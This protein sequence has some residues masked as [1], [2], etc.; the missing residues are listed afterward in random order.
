M[1][2][3][4]FSSLSS[5]LDPQNLLNILVVATGLGMVIFFHEL[6]HFLVAKWCGVYV[7][8][9]SIGF[10]PVILAKQWGETEYALS[11]LPFG[12][13][14]KML[15]QDDMDPGQMT[16]EQVAENPRSY[17]AKNVPQRM[18]I[19]SAGVIMNILTAVIFFMIAFKSGIKSLDPS[20]G[21]IQVGMPAWQH[22]MRAGDTITSINGRDVKEFNDVSRRTAL[23]RGS[24]NVKGIHDDGN[25]FDISIQPEK[26][27]ILRKIGVGP[28]NS[29]SV[30][31]S[32][33]PELIP[34]VLPGTS[35]ARSEIEGGD[36]IQAVD[37]IPVKNFP[38]F[39]AA[40]NDKKAQAVE[41]TVVRTDQAKAQSTVKVNLGAE[42]F[43][44]LGI[45][46]GMGKITSIQHNSI[47]EKAGLKVGDLISKVSIPAVIE[48]TNNATDNKPVETELSA[49]AKTQLDV[50]TDIDPFRLT[51]HF[52]KYSGQEVVVTVSREVEG[53]TPATLDIKLIPNDRDP[54][55]E[56]PILPESP[57]S[58][59]SLGIAYHL[60]P[61]VFAVKE[62]SDAAQGGILPRDTITKIEFVKATGG[63]PDGL[64]PDSPP[65]VVG[66]KN[67]A[68]AFWMMQEDARTRVVK[69]TV[70]P[71]DAGEV[72]T[73][74]LQPKEVED[75][76]LPTSRG[77][78]LD[79]QQFTMIAD[80]LPQAFDM[81]ANYALN[82]IEDIYLT[83]RGLVMRDISPKG[84]SGPIGIATIASG[85]A[86]EG[87]AMFVLFLGLISVNLAV[88]NFLPIPVLDGGH[89]VF[90]L[91]EGIT[92][93][94]PNEKV[95]TVATVVGLCIV[96]SLMILVIYLDIGRIAGFL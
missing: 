89:M 54:W 18:A 24:I 85:F 65:L 12:G 93:S 37:G 82:S 94:K 42:K 79:R 83:L 34:S 76:Y 17:S 30:F 50:G 96:G 29:L 49:P 56:P 31:L 20:V 47:A 41:L 33:Q 10:G 91:W 40:M 43:L 69:L 14:V 38:E 84:L 72:K 55:A 64:E 27:E 71:A 32:P 19:I 90:L 7:E 46:V 66:E 51:E 28:S 92:R 70:K 36:L 35:A 4:I 15:G 86:R 81:G 53:G 48:Q 13:Y 63:K 21:F 22:G 1:E 78:R 11:L 45:R 88:I 57:L 44:G 16:D 59:P 52:S 58:I 87:L 8:R 9:F 25:T 3:L 61:T 2:P 26:S 39:A 68:Y 62:G 80:T 74:E 60:V 75:W 67:W 5:I 6:G 95:V 77:L 73:A 23:S